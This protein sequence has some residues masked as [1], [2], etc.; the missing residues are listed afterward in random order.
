MFVIICVLYCRVAFGGIQPERLNAEGFSPSAFSRGLIVS[1]T[2]GIP[3][4]LKKASGGR[5]ISCH[6]SR[7]SRS[8]LSLQSE[9]DAVALL[10]KTDE[11][12]YNKRQIL[13][14]VVERKNRSVEEVNH[15]FF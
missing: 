11:N 6:G 2:P 12:Y 8:S 3:A 1:A 4:P 14:F 7:F 9:S 15:A 10:K 13:T 5:E